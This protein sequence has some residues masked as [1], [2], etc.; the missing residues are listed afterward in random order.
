MVGLGFELELRDGSFKDNSYCIDDEYNK[1]TIIELVLGFVNTFYNDGDLAG[2]PNHYVIS[3][4][5]FSELVEKGNV[6]INGYLSVTIR[7]Y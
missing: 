4:S 3:D 5:E 6:F 2:Y 1:E 7:N